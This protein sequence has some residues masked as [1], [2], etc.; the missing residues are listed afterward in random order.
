MGLLHNRFF[1]SLANTLLGAWFSTSTDRSLFEDSFPQ[2]FLKRP[3]IGSLV[4]PAGLVRTYPIGGT[5][6]F[7]T[8]EWLCYS[9]PGRL[10]QV[11]YVLS[12]SDLHMAVL[13]MRL[14]VQTLTE[15][16]T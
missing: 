3:D 5:I 16:L 6:A 13:S 11:L 15:S 14:L 9:A 1:R 7:L 8:A 2:R 10:L 12:R 4:K